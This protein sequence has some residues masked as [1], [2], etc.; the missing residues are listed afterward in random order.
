[1]QQQ[2]DLHQ[3]NKEYHLATTTR[4]NN[5][6]VWGLNFNPTNQPTSTVNGPT[7]KE[8]PIISF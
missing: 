6:W 3:L 7:G 1:M 4:I 8:R 5:V 2:R